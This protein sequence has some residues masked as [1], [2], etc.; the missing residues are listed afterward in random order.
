MSDDFIKQMPEFLRKQETQDQRAI[1][2]KLKTLKS[3]VP[4][5]EKKIARGDPWPG[6]V[7]PLHPTQSANRNSES[8]DGVLD[9]TLI[10]T[11]T[12]VHGSR[13]QRG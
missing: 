6:D 8:W 2:N 3:L 9:T 5:V 12:P 10:K 13:G 1:E 7:T 4:M 11:E